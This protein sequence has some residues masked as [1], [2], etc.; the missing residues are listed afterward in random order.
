LAGKAL[1]HSNFP[2]EH[3]FATTLAGCA[4]LVCVFAPLSARRMT[5]N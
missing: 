4:L 3:P 5:A 2:L 1:D